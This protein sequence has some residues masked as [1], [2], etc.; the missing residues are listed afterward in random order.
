[1]QIGVDFKYCWSKDRLV[2]TPRRGRIDAVL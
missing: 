1:M 2:A